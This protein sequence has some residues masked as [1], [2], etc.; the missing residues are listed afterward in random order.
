[1]KRI[2]LLA[3]FSVFFA[4]CGGGIISNNANVN[5]AAEPK[6]ISPGALS[7]TTRGNPAVGLQ[8]MSAYM[9]SGETAINTAD[10]KSVKTVMR[11][12]V[13]ANYTLDLSSGFSS[14]TS[15]LN[16]AGQ[17]QVFF[18]LQDKANA[19]KDTPFV[20]GD[21]PSKPQDQFE[22]FYSLAIFTYSETGDRENKILGGYDLTKGGV[23]ITSVTGDTVVGE[24][25]VTNG[26]NTVKG[27][28]TAKIYKE[29]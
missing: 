5:S 17:M 11:D 19:T 2:L 24:I 1:M 18:K 4:G 9:F 29:K 22:K 13:I 14:T 21:Y 23:K 12:F 8:P 26:E 25:D 27:P 6:P 15:P 20:A 7:V 10:G 3:G 16:A 28:F